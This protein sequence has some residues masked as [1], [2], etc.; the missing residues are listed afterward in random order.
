MYYRFGVLQPETSKSGL[1]FLNPITT[2]YEPIQ[3]TMQID[4]VRDISCGTSGGVVIY[5]T[6]SI[7]LIFSVRENRGRKQAKRGFGY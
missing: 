4:E 6:K 3:V 1:N 7:F 5:V 2:T